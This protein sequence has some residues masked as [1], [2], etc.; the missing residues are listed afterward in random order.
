MIHG[1]VQS[2]IGSESSAPKERKKRRKSGL[3]QKGEQ[4]GDN[5]I[6]RRG[7][8]GNLPTRAQVTANHVFDLHSA[9]RRLVDESGLRCSTCDA[10]LVTAGCKC[11]TLS[12]FDGGIQ[13]DNF[14]NFTE[15]K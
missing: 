5:P 6:L 15:R 11:N 1:H 14:P 4:D 2:K 3:G 9:P 7:R 10:S 12:W 13:R 8:N